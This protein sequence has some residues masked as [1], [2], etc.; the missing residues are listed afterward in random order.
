MDESYEQALSVVES[1]VHALTE[2]VPPPVRVTVGHGYAFRYAEKTIG[3]AL[4]QKLARLASGLRAA[5]LLMEQGYLQE[6]GA[7]Q[8]M[9]DEI[10]EDIH[11][12]AY[13]EVTG[14]KTQLHQEYLDAFYQEEFDAETAVESSQRRP[15]IPRR[16]I[17]TYLVEIET[18]GAERERHREVGRTLSKLYS[19]Y[20][21]AASPQI[22][23]MY[24]GNPPRF[25]M[26][27]NF[28]CDIYVEHSHDLWN[29]FYRALLACGVS[30]KAVGDDDRCARLVAYARDFAVQSGR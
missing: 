9:L 8:R 22:M 15:S 27:G 17:R 20:V 7:L 2:R 21:H 30:A 25:R 4:V 14:A 18:R 28:D 26:R 11:F 16:K 10:A 24:G 3:Q 5:N 1:T 29:Y 12:L 23:D 13:A 19:G 6:Q